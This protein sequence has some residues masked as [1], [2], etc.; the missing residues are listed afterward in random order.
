MREWLTVRDINPDTMKAISDGVLQHG[1]ALSE[2]RGGQAEAIACSLMENGALIGGAS[3][4]TEFR[5]LFVNYL[6]ISAQ[7]RG[8]RLGTQVLHKLEAL[9]VERACVD[10]LIETLDDDV[11]RW[12]TRCGYRLIAHVPEYCGPWSRHTLLKVLVT[13]GAPS[14]L[15]SASHTEVGNY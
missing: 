10:A 13:T 3:G 8:T 9:A 1:R 12:Y 4:R 2:A 15:N 6:W 5:R 11:A 14:G 7:W